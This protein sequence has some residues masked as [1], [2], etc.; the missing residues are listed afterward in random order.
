MYQFIEPSNSEPAKLYPR[1]HYLVDK[2]I[3]NRNVLIDYYRSNNKRL[4]NTHILVRLVKLMAIINHDY[5]DN[6]VDICTTA[7][8]YG[9]ELANTLA[10]TTY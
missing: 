10:I 4:P 8:R 7:Y 5:D 6:P 1:Q 3:R 2:Y 9:I